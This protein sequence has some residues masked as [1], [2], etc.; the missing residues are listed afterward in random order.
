VVARWFR[1]S[2]AEKT[3]RRH[4]DESGIALDGLRIAGALAA[5]IGFY[6]AFRAQHAR[7]TDAGDGLLWQWGPDADATRFTA[8]LTR[9]LIREGDDQPIVQVTLRLAYRWTPSRRALGRG[10]AWCF[11]PAEAGDFAATIR[12]SP[13]YRAIVSA[14]P[15]DVSLR[16]DVL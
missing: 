16:T 4:L 1:I 9:Q 13:A 8:G 15:V 12:R 10:H 2:L 11:S 14:A 5:T 7:L 6:T 3:F